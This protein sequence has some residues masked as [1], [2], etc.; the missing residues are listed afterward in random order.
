[1]ESVTLNKIY[2][3]L[4]A[5]DDKVARME[6]VLIPKERLGKKEAAE[7]DAIEREMLAGKRTKYSK[8]LF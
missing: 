4:K 2:S 6:Y 7:L 3:R 8:T 1:M 5:L